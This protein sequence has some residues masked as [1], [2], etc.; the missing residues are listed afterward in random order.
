MNSP[1][2]NQMKRQHIFAVNGSPEFLDVMRELFQEEN[3]NVTTTN[4]VPETFDQ[5]A[6]LNPSLLIIDLAVGERAG[7]N[8]LERL[9]TEAA[10]A[11]IPIIIVSTSS[12]LLEEAQ[13]DPARFG[14]KRFLH[15]PF[16]LEVV[17]KMVNDLIGPA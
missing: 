11:G 7:W 12:H 15:K 8:L 16:D 4:F 17:L 10:T 6:S 3:Y 1:E 13:D 2:Q 14:G 9:G 5:I